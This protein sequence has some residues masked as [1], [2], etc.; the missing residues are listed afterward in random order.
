MH[1]TDKERIEGEK[2][3]WGK[4]AKQ[5]DNWITEAFSEQYILNKSKLSSIIKSEDE[6]LEIGCGAGDTAYHLAPKCT[7]IIGTDLSPEMI[8]VAKNRESEYDNISFQV[9]DSYNL[10]FSDNSFDKVICV[11]ALQVM[12]EPKRAILEGM[13]ILKEGGEFASI[14]YLFGESSLIEY[15]KLT[16]WVIKYGKPKYWHN[17]KQSELIDI[18][19]DAG[20]EIIHEEIIWKKPVVLFLR[21]GKTKSTAV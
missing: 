2:K 17:F 21:C 14:T 7:K 15:F 5:Y 19:R 4:V 11:N 8:A 9:E 3:F 18:F 12:K 6:V 1:A 16:R 13:R 20:F 10:T